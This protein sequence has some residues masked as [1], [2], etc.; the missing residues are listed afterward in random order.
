MFPEMTDA[1][2]DHVAKSLREFY[3]AG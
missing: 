2:V 1:M 3:A